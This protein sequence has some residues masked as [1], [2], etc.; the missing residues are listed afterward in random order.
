MRHDLRSAHSLHDFKLEILQ[1]LTRIIGGERI[2]VW[3]YTHAFKV[4]SCGFEGDSTWQQS[5][6]Y[7]NSQGDLMREILHRM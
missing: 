1:D 4:V 5:T 2:R 7:M 3:T 6:R